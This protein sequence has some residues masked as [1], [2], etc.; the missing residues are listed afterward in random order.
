[1]VNECSGKRRLPRARARVLVPIIVVGLLLV[2]GALY[3]ISPV[4]PPTPYGEKT[5]RGEFIKQFLEQKV[6]R[7]DVPDSQRHNSFHDLLIAARWY[8]HLHGRKG[9]QE[10]RDRLIK[11]ELSEV[12][13]EFRD[14]VEHNEQPFAVLKKAVKETCVTP[15]VESFADWLPYLAVF[16]ELARG[17]TTRAR[18]RELDGDLEGAYE[19]YLDVLR[20]GSCSAQG[21]VGIIHGLVGIAIHSIGARAMEPGIRS[22]DESLLQQVVLG[23]KEVEERMPSLKEVLKGEFN[24]LEEG[25]EYMMKGR[26]NF[27]ALALLGDQDPIPRMKANLIWLY[28]LLSRGRI[29]R[30]FQRFKATMLEYADAPVSQS[31]APFDLLEHQIVNADHINRLLFPAVPRASTQW[32]R[33]RTR[34]RALLLRAAVELYERRQGRYP[35][36][37]NQ[38]V[39]AGII[40]A[41]PDDP[42]DGQKFR[43]ISSP[44]GGKIYSV[45]PD[46]VDDHAEIEWW[47]SKKGGRADKGDWVF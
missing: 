26:G 41:I 7:D 28:T 12:S 33:D 23:V 30:N 15:T 29:R 2:G 13:Q 27:G 18:I 4:P 24:V 40:P 46:L 38:L 1:V 6:K 10:E 11:N 3:I 25:V 22:L 44:E 14:Y 31:R 17:L 9:L 42:F 19:D 21:E 5:T 16:R 39:E 8:E 43:Y 32:V 35:E 20:L 45:G 36:D 37:L 47:P 34:L